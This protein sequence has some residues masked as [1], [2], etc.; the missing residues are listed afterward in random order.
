MLY[1]VKLLLQKKPYSFLNFKSVDPRSNPDRTPN[2]HQTNT[3]R[4]PNEPQTNPKRTP[5]VPELVIQLSRNASSL[6]EN[7]LSDTV[8]ISEIANFWGWRKSA[9]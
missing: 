8:K 5:I 1:D 4:T 9:T 6:R 7:V 3:K 2:E